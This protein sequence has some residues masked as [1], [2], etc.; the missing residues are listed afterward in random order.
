VDK[1]EKAELHAVV[2]GRVQGVFFRMFVLREAQS[3]GLCG[4]VR[5]RPDGTVEVL[6]EGDRLRLER[7]GE[8][9]RKGPSGAHVTDVALDWAEYSHQ[10]DD[11]SIAYD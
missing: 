7:L 4:W 8:R 11:F 3:L 5:N 9:L 2:S 1:S 6:A 10:F